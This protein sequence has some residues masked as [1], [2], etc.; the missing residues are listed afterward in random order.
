VLTSLGLVPIEQT[1]AVLLR[2][3]GV[4]HASDLPVQSFAR[5]LTEQLPAELVRPLIAGMRG[6]LE[7]KPELIPTGTNLDQ[8][9]DGYQAVEQLARAA[10]LTPA[11]IA[12]AWQLSRA[13]L[14]SSA[15]AVDASDGLEELLTDLTAQCACYVYSDGAD[16]AAL[17]V[18]TAIDLDHRVQLLPDSLPVATAR[19]LRGSGNDADRPIRILV[20]GTRWNGELDAAAAGCGT[21]LI[22]RY[23]L[24]RGSPD[25]R[26]A[27]LA[28]AT[29]QIRSWAAGATTQD[30]PAQP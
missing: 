28:R 1:S 9:E 14:T 10:G 19:L 2:L 24:G 16:P 11:Q 15:W 26:A 27:D 29:P 30:M 20:V 3:D 12:A 21:L 8:V 13:D 6:F 7:Q 23:G 25:W 5:H 17:S 18:L 22:D 4:V